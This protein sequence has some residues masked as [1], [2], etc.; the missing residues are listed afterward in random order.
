MLYHKFC[1]IRL[2]NKMRV[3]IVP[4]TI[5]QGLRFYHLG[6]F[7]H[8]GQGCKIGR[9]FTFNN[10]VLLGGGCQITIGG[11]VT[12]NPGVKVIKSV[13]IGNNVQVGTMAVVT[14]DI[15]DNAVVAGVPARILYI[16]N[17]Q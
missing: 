17:Q 3:C 14:H 2:G 8:I 10:G 13:S 9:H 11:N 7:I 1:Y 15:P 4:F 5:E 16:K 6:D 12:L